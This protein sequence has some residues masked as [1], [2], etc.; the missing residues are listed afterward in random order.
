M[1]RKISLVFI[2]GLL[3]QSCDSNQIF[4]QYQS[5]KGSW[6]KDS[7]KTFTFTPKDTISKRNLFV[8]LRNNNDYR[9]SN[10]F[11]IVE[12]NYPNGKTTTDT[13]QYKMTE[14]SGKFL[15]TGFS[16]LKENKLWYK[17][18]KEGFVFNESGEYSINIKHAMRENNQV[19]GVTNLKGITDVGFRIEPIEK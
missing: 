8:T 18:Y 11:L 6:H 12:F 14:P 19:N 10:L 1:L 9:F 5:V 13:L 3:I 15:G 2:L 17:G 16:D 7:V 4:D